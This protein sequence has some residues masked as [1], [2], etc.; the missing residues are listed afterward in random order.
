MDRLLPPVF[1]VLALAMIIAGFALW[2]VDPPEA[3]VELHA[4]VASGDD[5]HAEVLEERLEREQFK[6]QVLLVSLFAGS[7]LSIIAAFFSMRP[8]EARRR[9]D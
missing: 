9:S 4:A 8:A 7:G 5:Q 6:R 1:L 3:S 2:S